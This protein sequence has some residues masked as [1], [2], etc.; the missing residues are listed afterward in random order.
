MLIYEEAIAQILAKVVPL[1]PSAVSLTE[2]LGRV[3]A[4]DIVSPLNLP[5]F[6]NSAMDGYAVR[7]S[8]LPGGTGKLPI[9]GEIPAGAPAGQSLT[10]GTA[11]RIMTGAPMPNHADTVVPV[12]DT[13]AQG[14]QVL[15]REMEIGQF[16]RSEGE[17]VQA[18][19][20]V[21][22]ADTRIRPQEIGLLASVGR[23][24]VST[25]PRPR[26]A[27]ISTGDELIEPG[28]ALRPGQIYNSNGYALA[29]QVVDAGGIVVQRLH[30]ADT[31]E[32]LREAFDACAGADILLTSGG[33]SVGDFDY[34]KSVFAERGE[35]DFWRVA[36]RPG[37]PLAFGT[38]GNTLFFGLPGNPVSSLVTFELF[39]R[40]ALL[41]MRGL[42]D[43]SRPMVQARLTDAASHGTGRRSYQRAVA[44]EEGSEWFVRPILKQ[45][46][47]Q[48][49]AATEA[50]ALLIVPHDVPEIPEGE[51]ATVML[52]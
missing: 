11:L 44:W 22:T 7:A 36:I 3:L 18:G 49:R 24:T 45:G 10:P 1:S 26:V 48:L 32:A 41:K 25:Y 15:I 9:S 46:S 42:S 40:P 23:Q 39:V 5:P 27:I 16:M 38:W 6:A 29:A 43:L 35:V 31:P 2:A 12:E 20:V 30:A 28:Q 17:D 47:H 34:V 14:E 8:D 52:L 19:E 13:E 4:E 51:Y 33:V 21:L 37:K 50:N